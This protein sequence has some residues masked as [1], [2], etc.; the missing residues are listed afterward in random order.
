MFM[1]TG[2][3]IPLP[4]YLLLV[5]CTLISFYPFNSSSVEFSLIEFNA[6]YDYQ[7]IEPWSGVF[8]DYTGKEWNVQEF[9]KNDQ[10]SFAIKPKFLLIYNSNNFTE[11]SIY[12]DN[13]YKSDLFRVKP[14]IN[15]DQTTYFKITKNSFLGINTYLE[16]FG[17]IDESPC[18]DD[19]RREY[20]CGT[21][22]AW[23]DSYPYHKKDN[24]NSQIG[25]SWNYFFDWSINSLLHKNLSEGEMVFIRNAIIGD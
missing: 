2:N 12:G 15:I 24:N 6:I 22:L 21:G 14:K 11:L 8:K 17:G 18:Y 23:S 25:I 7:R 16:F 20:H 13:G 3:W 10:L 1:D 5:I 4:R 19:F 9:Y